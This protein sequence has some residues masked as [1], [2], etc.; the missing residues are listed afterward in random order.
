MADAGTEGALEFLKAKIEKGK[1]ANWDR[2]VEVFE[3]EGPGLVGV[4]IYTEVNCYQILARS[5]YDYSPNEPRLQDRPV[6][7]LGCQAGARR[8]RAGENWTRG[9][10]LADGP[11]SDDTWNQIMID[12]VSYEMVKVH[13]VPKDEAAHSRTVEGVAA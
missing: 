5:G 3:P 8:P 6:S 2:D 11:L 7:Y 12:I 10:D 4:R 13:R 1:F 9:N